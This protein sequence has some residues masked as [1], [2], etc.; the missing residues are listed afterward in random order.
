MDYAIK[1][2]SALTAEDLAAK[3]LTGIPA[4]WPVE[5]YPYEDPLLD[6][7]E[8]ITDEDL[9]LLGANNQ[10]SY[11]AWLQALRPIQ[12]V[13]N[14]TQEVVVK[15]GNLTAAITAPLDN[16]PFA[17]PTYRTK[18]NA[19][20]NWIAVEPDSSAPNDFLLTAE[21]YIAGG[22][23]LVQNA[24]M[25]DYVT[26]E[27]IDRDCVIPLQYRVALCENYPTVALYIERWWINPTAEFITVDLDTA[28][29]NAKISAGLY[30]RVTYH[31]SAAGTTRQLAINYKLTKKL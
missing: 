28:P 11:D 7:F 16:N 26:A 22:Q 17:V 13:T 27:V 31:A 15:S 29:L 23:L 21:R 1:R 4:D 6:G 30:L 3:G 2:A 10:A 8:R 9:A 24:T 5:I 19:T 18:Y 20:S 14:P 25:G 12:Q